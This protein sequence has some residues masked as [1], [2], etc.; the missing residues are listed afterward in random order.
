MSLTYLE[1]ADMRIYLRT[2][3]QSELTVLLKAYV[4]IGCM[5]VYVFICVCMNI[6]LTLTCLTYALCVKY[7]FVCMHE[8][9]DVGREVG[10]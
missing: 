4:S 5:N 3:L 9:M 6:S 8:C 1:Y 2:L 7:I 10:R